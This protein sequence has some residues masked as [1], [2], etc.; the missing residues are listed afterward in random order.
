M[1][2]YN[3][4]DPNAVIGTL[5]FKTF[6]NS[7]PFNSKKQD[8]NHE[9]WSDGLLLDLIAHR[10]PPQ[11][12]PRTTAIAAF[13]ACPKNKNQNREDDQNDYLKCQ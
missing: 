7:S 12:D 2:K 9:C 5:F 3:P 4:S 11:T 10:I 1:I 8:Q 13:S 6:Q